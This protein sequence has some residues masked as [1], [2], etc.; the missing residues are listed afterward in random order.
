[1]REPLRDVEAQ[2][3]LARVE[4]RVPSRVCT[5]NRAQRNADS[6]SRR[7]AR[8]NTVYTGIPNEGFVWVWRR[9]C[10]RLYEQQRYKI[11]YSLPR[12]ADRHAERVECAEIEVRGAARV[13]DEELNI[14][15]ER[16]LRLPLQRERRLRVMSVKKFRTKSRKTLT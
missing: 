1:M 7:G 16:R 13:R 10:S 15:D 4:P 3:I 8:S 6:G 2:R 14:V 5:R 11:G 9:P 12:V